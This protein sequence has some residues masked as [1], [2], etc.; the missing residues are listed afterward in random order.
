M[1]RYSSRYPNL[2]FATFQYCTRWKKIHNHGFLHNRI[3]SLIIAVGFIHKK[4]TYFHRHKWHIGFRVQKR[5]RGRKKKDHD[6]SKEIISFVS[7]CKFRLPLSL[8][9][10]KLKRVPHCLCKR[11]KGQKCRP[12]VDAYVP[13]LT[14]TPTNISYF[15]NKYTHIVGLKCTQYTHI[16]THERPAMP[17]GLIYMLPHTK[18][19]GFFASP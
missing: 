11:F 2:D 4:K 7:V 5:D 3:P 18:I 19:I 10:A 12:F 9:S 14:L 17:Y 15:A 6:I 13:T 16:H 1:H 8:P